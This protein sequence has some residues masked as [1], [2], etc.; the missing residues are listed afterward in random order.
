MSGKAE[1][2]PFQSSNFSKEET[3]K[4]SLSFYHEMNKRRSL[5]M[6]SEEPVPKKVLENIILTA[7]TAP[8]GAHKQPWTF[9]LIGNPEL[10]SEIRKA[11]E[12]EEYESYHGRMS[13]E[14]LRDLEKFDTNWHKPFIEIA[15]WIIVVFKRIYDLEDGEKK[16]NYYVNESVGIACGMLITAIH[17][18][19]LVTLT[20]TPSPMN[21]L[22]KILNRPSNERP[23]LLLPVGYAATNAEVP[24][25]SRK[26]LNEICIS[27]D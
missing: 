26:S 13:E 25:L 14:W 24:K 23:F 8:S 21:F 3:K 7:G 20:H 2:I 18:A 9:C 22:S 19:G 16:N 27:Y 4:R 17:Q 5:R 12:Q 15:P 11:A 10:K 6:F 1:F